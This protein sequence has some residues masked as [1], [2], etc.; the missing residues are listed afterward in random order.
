ML[1]ILCAQFLCQHD[2][3][4]SQKVPRAAEGLEALSLSFR[5]ALYLT[6]KAFMTCCVLHSHICA[7]LLLRLI[8]GATLLIW[9][10]QSARQLFSIWI[11]Y[12]QEGFGWRDLVLEL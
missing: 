10:L 5:L 6:P 11:S 9:L 3:N 12:G 7:I 8:A 2:A 1:V 4:A